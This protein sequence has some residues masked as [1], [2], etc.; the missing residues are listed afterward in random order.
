MKA[1]LIFFLL[2]LTYSYNREGAA[3]YAQKYCNN[4]NPEFKKY[5]DMIEESINFISQCI[6]I[7][8]GQDFEGCEGR[9]DKGMFKSVSD[10]KNCL[11][12]KGWKISYKPVKG[13]LVFNFVGN[14]VKIITGDRTDFFGKFIYCSHG[15][16]R[17][18][19]TQ[20]PLFIEYYSP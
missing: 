2:G 5:P 14:H 20:T 12:S 11:V 16:D 3:N 7:G 18:S 1:I 15:P 10:L 8:G 13:N 17:C 9:D 6:N 19:E 4:Y